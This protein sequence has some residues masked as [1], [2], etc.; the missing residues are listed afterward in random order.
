MSCGPARV[1]WIE[2]EPGTGKTRLMAELADRIDP[3]SS[4]LL[5]VACPRVAGAGAGCVP[6]LLTAADELVPVARRGVPEGPATS[7]PMPRSRRAGLAGDVVARLRIAAIGARARR[8]RR[9]R[10]VAGAVRGGDAPRDHRRARSTWPAGSSPADPSDR[11]PAAA[12]L[13]GDLERAGAVRSVEL[14]NLTPA[15]VGPSSTT[16]RAELDAAAR[17]RLADDV[18]VG[19]RRPPAVGRRGRRATAT[20]CRRTTGCRAST[21]SSPA[22]WPGSTPATGASSTCS[23]SPPVRAPV[24][25]LAAACDALAGARSSSGPSALLDEGLRRPRSATATLDLRHDLVRR[26]VERHLPPSAELAR[27]PRR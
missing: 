9:R 7:R 6:A 21:P 23:P 3:D 25:V 4:V 2:G 10:A 13:H 27:P 26:A 5:Y 22:R 8:R 24:T 14:G 17:D 15:D 16:S 12:A 18:S 19:D 11:H 1:V 20:G